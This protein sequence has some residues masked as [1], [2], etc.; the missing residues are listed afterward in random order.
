MQTAPEL[1]TNGYT[2]PPLG[3]EETAEMRA[4]G[5]A[6]DARQRQLLLAVTALRD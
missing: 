2:S 3:T 5:S 6:A 4:A 1:G